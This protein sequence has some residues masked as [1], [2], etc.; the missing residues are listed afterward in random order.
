MSHFKYTADVASF[1][2]DFLRHMEDEDIRSEKTEF[3]AA[4]KQILFHY[5]E[6]FRKGNKHERKHLVE[7]VIIP[8]IRILLKHWPRKVFKAYR[9]V[10]IISIS[11]FNGVLTL[12]IDHKAMVFQQWTSSFRVAGPE[13]PSKTR[14]GTSLIFFV[15]RCG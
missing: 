9:P 14:A 7:D 8:E 10:L 1:F 6:Q 11:A 2:P 13:H 12:L 5:V 3:S 4:E 15:S